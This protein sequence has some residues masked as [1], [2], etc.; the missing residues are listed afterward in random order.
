MELRSLG[1]PSLMV[2]RIGLGLAALGRPGYI[3]LGHADDL[4]HSYDVLAM[5]A[6]CHAVLDLAWE[7]GVRY[8]DV[9]RSYGRAEA[10]LADWLASRRIQPSAAAIGSKWGYSYTADWKVEAQTHEIKDHSLP[11][12]QRQAAESRALLGNHLDLYQIHS[13]TL[14][15]GVLTDRA[16]LEELARM[17]QSGLR[18]GLT[19]SGPE[20]AETLGRALEIKIAGDR[21]FDCVQAT[22]NLLEPSTGPALQAARAAGMGVIV[23]EALANGRVDSPQHRPGL[24]CPAEDP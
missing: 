18:I 8:F 7:L 10:F 2:T 9:A 3:N 6:H 22:W 1:N 11:V 16:V 13:A 23:K 19:L 4:E 20:Q 17:R 14:E 21:L 24:C 5:E 12:L 15:S